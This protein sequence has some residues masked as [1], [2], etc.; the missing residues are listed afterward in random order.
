MSTQKDSLQGG[1][2]QGESV[3]Q[4]SW[5][6]RLRQLIA[7]ALA[8]FNKLWR[9]LFLLY[10]PIL[11]LF[12]ILR[13]VSYFSDWIT[14]SYF[15]R[16]IAAIARLPFYA[17]AVSQIGGLL[18]A[19]SLAICIFTLLAMQKHGQSSAATRRWL[20]QAA[21]LTAIL[22]FDD[23]FQF[24][25]AISEEYLGLSQRLVVVSYVLVALIFV[26]ISFNEIISSEYL[27]LGLALFLFGL[28]VFLDSADF[29]NFGA[30]GRLLNDQLHTFVEDGFKFAGVV[31]WLVYFARYGYQKLTR[32]AQS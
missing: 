20:I 29:E 19:A 13:I 4:H 25:E 23:V 7:G 9:L 31:T 3:L 26:V 24:H 30:V 1:S 10:V 14:L 2:P 16:D 32:V 21:I 28:S 12:V 11:L 17:G 18:W 22:M 6:S 8:Q 15:T 27:I 5:S